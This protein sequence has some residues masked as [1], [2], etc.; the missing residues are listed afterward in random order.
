MTVQTLMVSCSLCGE[1]KMVNAPDIQAAYVKLWNQGWSGNTKTPMICPK[2]SYT[3][4]IIE[5]NYRWK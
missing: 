4:S 1:T 5:G 2:H 3:N